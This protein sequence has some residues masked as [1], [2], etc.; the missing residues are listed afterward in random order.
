MGGF[1]DFNKGEKKKM[2]KKEMEKRAKLSMS[3][4]GGSSAFVLPKI[5][6]KKKGD[7]N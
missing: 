1:G 2:S 5:I 7:W 3:S 6:E 4:T